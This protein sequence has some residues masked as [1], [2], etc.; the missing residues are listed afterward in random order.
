M[1]TKIQRFV[2]KNSRDILL[3]VAVMLVS[4]FSF[5]LGYITSKMEDKEPLHFE[6][7]IYSNQEESSD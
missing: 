5:S 3:F 1:I 2:K 4:L 7:P 6:E